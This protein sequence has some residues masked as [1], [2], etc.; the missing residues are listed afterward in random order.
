MRTNPLA[1]ILLAMSLTACLAHP[2][3]AEDE[4][5]D[6]TI[7]EEHTDHI[8][9]LVSVDI[10]TTVDPTQQILGVTNDLVD[11]ETILGDLFLNTPI[12]ADE[13]HAMRD[14]GD[15]VSVQC[16]F[17][18]VAELTHPDEPEIG[19]VFESQGCEFIEPE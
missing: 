17:V 15:P 19:W 1:T 9:T 12:P 13:V 5:V 8:I 4:E 14:A 18:R 7:I 11:G 2:A 16:D 6:A 3:F 10:Y